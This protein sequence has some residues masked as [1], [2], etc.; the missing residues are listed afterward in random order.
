MACTKIVP[1]LPLLYWL[2]KGLQLTPYACN[3]DVTIDITQ[4][5]PTMRC[6]H[7]VIIMGIARWC[8]VCGLGKGM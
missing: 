2:V 4:A 5:R 3:H 6:I 8:S 7:L 1:H